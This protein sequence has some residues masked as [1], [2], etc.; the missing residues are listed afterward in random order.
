MDVSSEFGLPPILD[1][2]VQ[3]EVDY[4]GLSTIIA[5]TLERS[6]P[7]RSFA[8]WCHGWIYTP[9]KYIAQFISMNHGFPYH[10]VATEKEVAFLNKAGIANVL[11]AGLPF[12]YA[13]RSDVERM[14]GSLLVMPP[15]SLSYVKIE[16]DEMDYLHYIKAHSDRFSR[17]V[18]CLHQDCINDGDW[19]EALDKF[20]F[21]WVAGASTNDFNSLER[22]QKLFRTFEYMTTCTIGSQLLYGA[23][24]GCKVSIAGPF[25]EYQKTALGNAPFYKTYPEIL[26]H[27]LKHSREQRVRDKYPFLFSVPHE[28]KLHHDWAHDVIG[29]C[30]RKTPAELKKILGWDL[31]GQL[32]L[33]GHYLKNKTS[34]FL[35]Q[36][37]HLYQ[38][39]FKPGVG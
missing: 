6:K 10:L 17:V 39:F 15:H 29:A 26:D 19:P 33:R 18:F 37:K 2:D 22:M 30:Y 5:K 28:A 36:S 4:Y 14:P 9:K 7:P 16:F 11:A 3:S 20:G 25:F 31:P 23:Y 27:N 24:C 13:D 1:A 21:D 38:R 32:K 34:R 8:T 35:E 12:I